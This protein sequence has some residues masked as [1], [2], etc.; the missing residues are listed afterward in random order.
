MNQNSTVELITVLF[1]EIP[2]NKAAE[3][4]IQFLI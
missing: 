4:W 2:G 1:P 3:N